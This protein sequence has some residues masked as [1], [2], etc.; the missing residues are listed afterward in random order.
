M[1]SPAK[2][3]H[4]WLAALAALILPWQL[5]INEGGVN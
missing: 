1:S 5:N 4:A 3:R 2:F